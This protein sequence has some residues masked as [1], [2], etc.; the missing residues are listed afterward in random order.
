MDVGVFYAIG[1]LLF[2]VAW[3]TVFLVQSV[4]L[5]VVIDCNWFPQ[6]LSILTLLLVQGS[7]LHGLMVVRLCLPGFMG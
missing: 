5:V 3:F 7:I 6:K 2:E 1:M 4:L